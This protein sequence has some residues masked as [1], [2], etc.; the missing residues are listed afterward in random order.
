MAKTYKSDAARKMSE[1][2]QKPRGNPP[3]KKVGDGRHAHPQPR[4]PQENKG[5]R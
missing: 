3:A 1:R 4:G 2:P 5:K